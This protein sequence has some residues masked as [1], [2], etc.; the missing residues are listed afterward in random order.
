VNREFDFL[1]TSN[2]FLVATSADGQ[3]V[4]MMPCC[5]IIKREEALNLAAWI[6]ALCDP[7]LKQF[8]RLVQAIKES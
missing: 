6:V 4:C 1:D 5:G 3:R 8:Q 7:E 2:Q